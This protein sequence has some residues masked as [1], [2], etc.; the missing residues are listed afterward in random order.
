MKFQIQILMNVRMKA[1]TTDVLSVGNMHYGWMPLVEEDFVQN[2]V[3]VT[4]L[5]C[6]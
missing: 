6:I 2:V 3:T 4:V 1:H 5:D